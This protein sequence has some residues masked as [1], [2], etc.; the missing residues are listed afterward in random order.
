MSPRPPF[1]L[2]QILPPEAPTATG[3]RAAGSGAPR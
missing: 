2:S 3:G 1:T